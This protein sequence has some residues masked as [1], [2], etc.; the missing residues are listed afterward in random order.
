MKLS[1]LIFLAASV[2]N[3]SKFKGTSTLISYANSLTTLNLTT[4]NRSTNSITS[5]ELC[6]PVRHNVTDDAQL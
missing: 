2:S 6:S 1:K 5:E 3:T 4:N